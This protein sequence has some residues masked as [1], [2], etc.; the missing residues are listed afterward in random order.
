MPPTPQ[1]NAEDRERHAI[2]HVLGVEEKGKGKG[3]GLD[4]IGLDAKAPHRKAGTD[5]A[6]SGR[7]MALC[8]E[9]ARRPAQP[10][11]PAAS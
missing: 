11:S 9:V 5:I 3:E 2:L 7:L 10:G 6:R 4:A 1:H 8:R